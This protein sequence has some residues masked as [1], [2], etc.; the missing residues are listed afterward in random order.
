MSSS[1]K[2]DRPY[3]RNRDKSDM[4]QLY[5]IIHTNRINLYNF[6]KNVG[7]L[8]NSKRRRAS[9]IALEKIEP[10]AKKEQ[11]KIDKYE[12]ILDL[13][14]QGLSAYK[15]AKIVDINVEN[16][17]SIVY[18]NHKPQLYNARRIVSTV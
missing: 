11:Y 10:L 17:K 1:V 13:R 7:F 2:F 4:Q 5:F 15:I 14:K 18:Y 3:F 12:E 16:I 9:E 8:H 6:I